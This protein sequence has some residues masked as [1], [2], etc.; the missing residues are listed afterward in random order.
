MNGRSIARHAAGIAALALI[1]VAWIQG[2]TDIP[3]MS[4]VIAAK[5]ADTLGVWVF[6][7]SLIWV[8]SA[9]AIGVAWTCWSRDPYSDTAVDHQDAA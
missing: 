6:T 2:L 8:A 4:A 1:P 9:A 7:W 3:S 5:T